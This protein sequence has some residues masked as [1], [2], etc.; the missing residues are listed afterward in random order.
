VEPL[1]RSRRGLDER[2]ALA[3]PWLGRR[4]LRRL[5]R[6]PAGSSL[7]RSVLTRALRVSFAANNRRDYVAMA[8]SFHPDIEFVPPGRGESGLDFDPVYRGPDGV[9]RFVEQWK[10]GFGEFR[11]E[12][13]EI[14]DAGGR[15]FAARIGLIGT[16]GESGAEVA[17]EYG[18]VYTSEDGLLRRIV[19]H[20]DWEDA[21]ADLHDEGTSRP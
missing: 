17:D 1:E 7:R 21:L 4:M 14:A 15:R 3:A 9:Q 16:V 10:S 12:P 20:F 8:S 19:N 2:L 13:R 11:Y 18:S 6:E 5:E